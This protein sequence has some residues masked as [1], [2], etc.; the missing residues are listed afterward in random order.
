M[1]EPFVDARLQVAFVRQEWLEN[2]VFVANKVEHVALRIGRHEDG[3][4]GAPMASFV[5]IL[6]VER[7]IPY[8]SNVG[9]LEAPLVGFK[10]QNKYNPI[11]EDDGI[12]ASPQ[13]G[14]VVFKVNTP[15][16]RILFQNILQQVDFFLPR[17]SLVDG[18]V[19]RTLANQ[20]SDNGR[21]IL[22]DEIAYRA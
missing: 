19:V 17:V 9:S 16:A 20:F 22:V 12:N 6:E 13:A 1:F 21:S 8:L 15:S 18:N 4:K 3:D 2:Q 10:L 11:N 14:D 5:E 7:I